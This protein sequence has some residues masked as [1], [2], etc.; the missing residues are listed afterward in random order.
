MVQ[1]AC[2]GF[3]L[4]VDQPGTLTAGE[5]FTLRPGP[6]ALSIADAIHA[7]WAKHRRD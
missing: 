4:A 3:Y 5:P 6:R 7:K 1:H 2:C